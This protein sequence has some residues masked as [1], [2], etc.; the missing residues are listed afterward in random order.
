[1]RGKTKKAKAIGT[2]IGRDAFA[3]IS[4]VEGM[5]LTPAMKRRAA[6]FDRK[7]LSTEERVRA[8]IAVQRK[9]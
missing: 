1:M 6:E 4:A 2:K 9:G 3:T 5:Q 7:G 8:V